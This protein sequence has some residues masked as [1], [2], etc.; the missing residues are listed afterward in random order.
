[1]KRLLRVFGVVTLLGSVA[2]G[3]YYFLFMRSR[4]SQVELY[5]DDGSMLAMPGNAAEA[6]PF[7]TVATEI[8]RS[9]P[10]VG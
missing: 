6:E 7:M 1:M 8:L 4:K 2:A 3:G 5:F 10:V 9:N